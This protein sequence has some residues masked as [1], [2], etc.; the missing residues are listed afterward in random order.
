MSLV[1]ALLWRFGIGLGIALVG[2]VLSVF[3]GNMRIDYTWFSLLGIV[4]IVLAIVPFLPG[5]RRGNSMYSRS[6]KDSQWTRKSF[7][8]AANYAISLVI[9]GAVNIAVPLLVYYFFKG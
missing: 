3:T 1:K 9:V 6:I 4:V 5:S 7:D 2:V 8:A